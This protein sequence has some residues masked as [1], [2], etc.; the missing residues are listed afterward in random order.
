MRAQLPEMQSSGTWARGMCWGPQLFP[1]AGCP[2]WVRFSCTSG[3]GARGSCV[4]LPSQNAS[5]GRGGSGFPFLCHVREGAE[6]P[7][8][9]LSVPGTGLWWGPP[10]DGPCLCKV[11]PCWADGQEEG[12][13]HIQVFAG[14]LDSEHLA[15]SRPV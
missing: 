15:P 9:Q 12:E 5:R 3:G 4:L 10:S 13:K 1:S 6:A 7:S 11:C 8:P 2:N 14:D